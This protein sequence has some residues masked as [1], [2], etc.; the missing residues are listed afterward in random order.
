MRPDQSYCQTGSRKASPRIT[1]AGMRK[2]TSSA[3]T[4]APITAA[5]RRMMLVAKPLKRACSSAAIHCGTRPAS[6]PATGP[7]RGNQSAWI[8]PTASTR[9][10]APMARSH[11]CCA[12]NPN[13]TA[14]IAAAPR[15][16]AS[17]TP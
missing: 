8:A 3:A 14:T 6:T 2:T 10:A 13:G 12:R 11:R 1:A 16:T 15:S 17:H 4:T 7:S 9:I 5:Q